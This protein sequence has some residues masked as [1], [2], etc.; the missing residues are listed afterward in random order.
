MQTDQIELRLPESCLRF[1]TPLLGEGVGIHT[2]FGIP[3]EELLCGRL[4]IPHDYLETRIQTIFVNG[5]AVDR[6][7][8]ILIGRDAV[9]ALSAAMPGLMGAT[10]RRG[11][12][13]SA[14]RREISQTDAPAEG[15]SGRGMV[16]LKLFN[17]VAREMGGR[18]LE[19]GVSLAAPRFADFWREAGE[20]LLASASEI[21]LNG[22]LLDADQARRWSPKSD[23]VRLQVTFEGAA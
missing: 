14:M 17:M 22:T 11:G 13:F 16:T 21:R 6:M 1:F 9:I 18:I 12:F 20:D 19:H 7:E 23:F 8:Q 10:L 15:S 4:G 5:R 2:D 3:L